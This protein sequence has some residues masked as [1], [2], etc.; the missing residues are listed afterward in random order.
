MCN[1][2][3]EQYFNA[4]LKSGSLCPFK[5]LIKTI[6]LTICLA[7]L[8]DSRLYAQTAYIHMGTT[9]NL[10]NG[11]TVTWNGL[12]TGD[13]IKWGYSTS[14]EKGQFMAASRTAITLSGNWFSYN[15]GN[16]IKPAS[17]IYY[18]IKDAHTSSW[19]T[20]KAYHTVAAVPSDTAA[21]SFTFAAAGDSRDGGTEFT[22]IAHAIYNK[23][24][25]F[26]AFP[27][28][29]TSKGNVASEWQSWF[30][31]VDSLASNKVIFPC[32][33]NHDAK[34]SKTYLNTFDLPTNG[35]G[36]DYNF[37]SFISLLRV[38]ALSGAI[39]M[40]QFYI[41]FLFFI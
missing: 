16:N 11:L 8:L 37:Y 21:Y 5:N 19:G 40:T 39:I 31:S 2:I 28:D 7:G 15:F 29:L 4:M 38:Y 9:G 36:S 23:N 30:G 20:Q 22:K 12:G 26:L 34:S 41:K 35:T 33:G 32:E 13:S 14:F 24:P 27:G 6:C 10:L 18:K 25:D 17:V 1:L 3:F